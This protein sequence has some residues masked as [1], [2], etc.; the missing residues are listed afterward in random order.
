MINTC[1]PHSGNSVSFQGREQHPAQGIA[2]GLAE[3]RF[4]G[5]KLKNPFKI[6]G[7]LHYDFVGF[8]KI[9][10]AHNNN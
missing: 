4:E 9:E 7:L 10:Y 1:N 2:Y 8:L 3:A 6:V 5:L